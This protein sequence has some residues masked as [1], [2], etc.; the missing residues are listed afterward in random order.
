[1]SSA[2][3]SFGRVATIAA[4]LTALLSI[5]SAV[6]SAT[7]ATA[8]LPPPQTPMRFCDNVPP[9]NPFTDNAAG[10][11]QAN[12]IC[13]SYA[14][15]TH[16]TSDPTLYAPSQPVT[17]AQ[18]AT[19]VARALDEAFSLKTAALNQLPAY[20]GTNQ[21]PDVSDTDVHVAD[22]NRL[23]QAGI[24]SGHTDGTFGPSENVSRAQMAKFI[25][26]GEKFLTGT[27]YS[28]TDDYFTDD[29]GNT[30]EANI[31][32]IASQG[33]AQGTGGTNY[34]PANPVSRAQMA[35]FLIRWLAVE[36]DGN[37]I[38][39]LPPPT[40][41]ASGI[42][43][44][45]DTA[46]NLYQFVPTGGTA[47]MS[48]IYD[49]GDTF[50]DDG[51][52]ATLA[53]FGTDVSVGDLVTLTTN[54]GGPDV[55]QHALTNKT[56]ASYT[57]GVVGDIDTSAVPLDPNAH[58]LTIIEPVTGVELSGR[59]DYTSNAKWTVNGATA[60]Q[61]DF[62]NAIN[63][64]DQLSIVAGSGGAQTLFALTDKSVSG[65][66]STVDTA[67]HLVMIGN[68]GDDPT[69]SQDA[70][71]D[72]S[73][74]GSTWT[75]D[76][77]TAANADDFGGNLTVGDQLTY[78]R[79]AGVQTFAL[80]NHA[81][82]PVSGT[83]TE[84]HS[85]SSSGGGTVTIVKGMTRTDITYTANAKFFVDGQLVTEN[86]SSD[87]NAFETKLTAGDAL[88]Y[89]PGDAKTNT[90]EAIFLTNASP[91]PSASGHLR[92]IH[93]Q[94]TTY[95]IVNDQDGII[96]DNL[97]YVVPAIPDFGQNQ[98]TYFVKHPG[99]TAE[100]S[101]QEPQWEQYM[102]AIG[103]ATNPVADIVVIGKSGAIEHHL[104]TDVTV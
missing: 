43:T 37:R 85:T 27:A 44:F 78:T 48:V 38:R 56:A 66:V 42:V 2:R 104:F 24:I 102:T 54:A 52:S 59:I 76:G 53:K 67:N 79:A 93:G 68:L 100:T 75:V 61:A 74:A 32:A 36:H 91:D 101:L 46:H 86:S 47:P 98:S 41:T 5:G 16:G 21:F 22:I 30:H 95:D 8:T 82:P 88:T 60:T 55:N 50:T 81:P 77:A 23:A 65:V 7:A 71:Y 14:G 80:V 19:F 92:D 69:G 45:V 33:I 70:S 15:I 58:T 25:N 89:Q 11:H 1:M 31:N 90:V 87:P 10:V 20:D 4:M 35:S 97:N 64:G 34:S 6:N 63:E 29:D 72:Y 73:L 99:D 96:V 94:G 103:A 26:N 18:M 40:I 62:E 83:V 9:D 84:S 12:I 13:L 57:S 28:T 49:S 3:L 39:R 51:S 17:R